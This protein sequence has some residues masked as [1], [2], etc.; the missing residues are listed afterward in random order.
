MN[1]SDDTHTNAEYTVS[2]N[3]TLIKR[4]KGVFDAC[5][6]TNSIEG[7]ATCL[8]LQQHSHWPQQVEED[9]LTFRSWHSRCNR[10]PEKAS[11]NHH[12]LKILLQQDQASCGSM[13][14]A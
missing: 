7:N 5:C 2:N 12:R 14:V 13:N 3:I 9:T 4:E 1:V 11:L 10:T 6:S 8:L